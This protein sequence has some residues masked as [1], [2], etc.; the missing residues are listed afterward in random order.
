MRFPNSEHQLG[1]R[2]QHRRSRPRA[3]HDDIICLTMGAS[4]LQQAA[5][6]LQQEQQQHLEGSSAAEAAG[7]AMPLEAASGASTG[8]VVQSNGASLTMEAS[9]LRTAA[10][11]AAA[12]ARAAAAPDMPDG[13]GGAS[14][15]MAALLERMQRRRRRQVHQ[16]NLECWRGN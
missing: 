6:P 16:E 1:R 12:A 2:R 13:W 11:T 5:L 4:P 9:P 8:R 15:A 14:A 10:P 7:P 3:C